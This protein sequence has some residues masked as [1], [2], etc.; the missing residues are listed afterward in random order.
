MEPPLLSTTVTT[1]H[2][3]VNYYN[4]HPLRWKTVPYIY[5]HTASPPSKWFR[6]GSE[7]SALAMRRNCINTK[8]SQDRIKTGG[9]DEAG[10][11]RSADLNY[12]NE[13]SI[14]FTWRVF[15]SMGFWTVDRF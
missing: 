2:P 5:I 1:V 4:D 3:K 12:L 7:S 9:G 6:L 11:L 15:Y 13:E 14:W 8:V 10:T